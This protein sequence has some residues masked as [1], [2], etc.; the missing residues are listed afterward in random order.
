MTPICPPPICG[1]VDAHDGVGR[2]HLAARQL[3]R[4]ED[5]H[6]ALHALQRLERLESRLE[7][8]VADRADDRA[9]LSAAHVRPESERL[10]A[11]TDVLDVPVHGSRLQ[12]DD[13]LAPLPGGPDAVASP[14]SKK[15]HAAVRPP[16]APLLFGLRYGMGPPGR[17]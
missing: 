17:R 15:G 16:V 6:H 2:A 4:L 5:R 12:Y 9:L 3:E 8:V 1:A 7:P 11:A 13:H 14:E 10:D